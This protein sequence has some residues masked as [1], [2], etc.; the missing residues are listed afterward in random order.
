MLGFWRPM[1]VVAIMAAIL[2]GCGCSWLRQ[3][4]K[5][6]VL[7][8]QLAVLNGALTQFTND[9]GRAPD[10]V[11]DLLLRG[12]LKELP[13]DPFTGR[14]DTWQLTASENSG[15]PTVQIHSGSEATSSAG[16]PY[17]QW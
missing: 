12:Y 6:A 9:T 17:G 7:R 3:V 1:V 13:V 4:R 10:S 16:T 2:G 14:N 15:M 8:E 11:S 5:E